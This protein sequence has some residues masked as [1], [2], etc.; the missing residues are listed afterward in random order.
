MTCRLQSVGDATWRFCP[1]NTPPAAART[2]CVALAQIV[3]DL[4]LA[5]PLV[6]MA[7]SASPSAFAGRSGPE[8]L[9][10]AVG[11]PFPN[12]PPAQVAGAII[13][14]R[15]AAPGYAPLALTG[16]LA[17]QPGYP[18]NFTPLDFGTWRLARMQVMIAGRVTRLAGG[19]AIPVAGANIAITGAVPAPP[20]AGAQ[21][22]PPPAASFLA[23][24]AVSDAA[25]NF[26]LGPVARAL[27]LTLTASEGGSTQSHDIDLD[28]AEPFNLIDFV[29]P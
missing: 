28:Y 7:V 24:A 18:A 26:R 22:P 2:Q 20:L 6:P 14:L 11:Q 25:G 27:R 19:G 1:D 21:P 9:V 12:L 29:L 16:A 13:A 15:I 3:D 5:P 17:A 4:A 23:L 8:G 10:G